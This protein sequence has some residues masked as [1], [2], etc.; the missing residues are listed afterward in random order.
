MQVS[1]KLRL[2][3]GLGLAIFVA[4]LLMGSST[5]PSISLGKPVDGVSFAVANKPTLAVDGKTSTAWLAKTNTYPQSITLN[6]QAV[7][8]IR[9]MAITFPKSSTWYYKIEGS[10]DNTDN[11]QAKSWEIIV[12]RTKD[13]AR[14]MTIK[15]SVKAEYRY[16]K[17]TITNSSDK[18]TAGVSEF[19]VYGEVVKQPR[20]VVPKPVPVSTGGQL[21]IAQSCN[22]WSSEHFWNS[23]AIEKYPGLYP[24]LGFYNESY[25]VPT[26][27]Q[28][29]MA[30]EN[31]VS[32]FL[33]CWYRHP[34]NAGKSPVMPMYDGMVQSLANS[35]Q[36]RNQI[37]WA[38]QWINPETKGVLSRQ[39]FLNN[40]AS[41]WIKNYFNKPNYLKVNGKPVISIYD[42]AAFSK[43]VGGLKEAKLALTSFRQMAKKAG[44]PDLLILTAENM[45][46]TDGF[47]F[48]KEA[49][50]DYVYSYHIP[51]F[52]NTRPNVAEPTEDDYVKSHYATWAN[53]DKTSKVPYI[54]TATMGW[55]A[56]P[57]GGTQAIF[58]ISPKK[59]EGLLQEAKKRMKNKKG[60]GAQMILLDNWNEY[61]EGHYIAPTQKHGYGYLNA[62]RN[63]FATTK[64]PPQNVMPDRSKIPQIIKYKWVD[65][66]S[67]YT[68]NAQREI[69]T[70]RG[71]L[72]VKYNAVTQDLEGRLTV[73]YEVFA[74]DGVTPTRL[75]TIDKDGVVEAK[76]NGKVKVKAFVTHQP[77]QKAE[78]VIT[79]RGQPALSRDEARNSPSLI[80]AAGK[81]LAY[82]KFTAVN[83]FWTAGYDQNKITDGDMESAWLIDG[84]KYPAWLM[85]DLG[86]P[87]EIGAIVQ[88]FADKDVRTYEYYIE[89]SMNGSEWTMLADRRNDP[90]TGPMVAEYASGKYKFIRLTLTKAIAWPSSK[91]FEVFSKDDIDQLFGG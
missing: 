90:Q 65:K 82:N 7:S 48:E 47:A 81:N 8:S 87:Q 52:M 38:I 77:D 44:F 41:F 71:Q 13:G 27:W 75:A 86:Q 21:V 2:S 30:L 78:M 11:A 84:A 9:E 19:V 68:D 1:A 43:D 63:V 4:L 69:S 31:G 91:E 46:P 17:L 32:G 85:V 36:H 74:E 50:V 83:A 28:I 61:G 10:F 18:F 6:L 55:D 24:Y 25:D 73:R 14:G 62:V 66:L 89:G 58:E 57:W 64:A 51:T 37:K 39:D 49:G 23:L 5:S 33:S 67:L 42:F 26:D 29:K 76:G 80:R 45:N 34:D 56:R 59:Y 40:L 60:L 72:A 12:D 22:L 15:D 16:L 88:T 79:L 54:Y 3:L 70:P 53:F 35:A 20:N